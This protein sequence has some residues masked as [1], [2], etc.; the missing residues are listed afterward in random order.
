MKSVT[1]SKTVIGGEGETLEAGKTYSLNDASAE[2]W[3][4]RSAAVASDAKKILTEDKPKVN[5]KIEAEEEAKPK[6]VEPEVKKPVEV[7]EPETKN[8]K[9]SRDK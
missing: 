3:I 5:Q 1:F 7:P 8:Q 2:R 6:T 4:K 9:G